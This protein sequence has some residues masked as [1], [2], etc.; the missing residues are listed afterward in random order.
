MRPKRL[1]AK[2]RC[3]RCGLWAQYPA[4]HHEQVFAGVCLWYQ[5]RLEQDLVY[6]ERVCG[7]FFER[8]P[9]LTPLEHFNYKTSRD[10]LG[11]A[12]QEARLGKRLAVLSAAI[13]VT[14][15]LLSLFG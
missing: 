11:D 4:D 2:A 1:E 14:S 12:Y 13:S 15:F 7:D 6:E 10:A 9:D 5:T 8:V 3:G